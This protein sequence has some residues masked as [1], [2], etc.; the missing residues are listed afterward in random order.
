MATE[1]K[2]GAITSQQKR[3]IRSAM[4]AKFKQKGRRMGAAQVGGGANW[5]KAGGTGSLKGWTGFST[6]P[7]AKKLE[8][9]YAQ[10][11]RKTQRAKD[12]A[13]R[14]ATR[15]TAMGVGA[16]SPALVQAQ[17]MK[18]IS[19]GGTVGRGTHAAVAGEKGGGAKRVA[20]KDWRTKH[21]SAAG[22]DKVKRA[23]VQ[24]RFKH[25]IGK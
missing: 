10:Q 11:V 20:A 1:D 2:W 21:M 22:T 5:R 8:I 18:A 17:K 9:S 14:K 6:N 23:K 13:G 7:A 25:M 12:P 3:A 4:L 16:K 24:K 15:T 19:K